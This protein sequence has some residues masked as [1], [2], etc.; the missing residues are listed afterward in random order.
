ME[1]AREILSALQEQ[2]ATVFLV[3]KREAE[4]ENILNELAIAHFFTAVHFVEHKEDILKELIEQATEPVY[5]VGDYLHNEIRYGNKYGARTVWLKRGRFST[6]VPESEYDTP[7]RT[8]ETLE[9][10]RE[11]IL[12]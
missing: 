8:I 7:W 9:E 12:D 11:L 3:S 4:R 5:V 6:L 1:G 2:S 10:L